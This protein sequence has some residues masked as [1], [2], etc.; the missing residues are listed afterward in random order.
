MM[1]HRDYFEALLSNPPKYIVVTPE[2]EQRFTIAP[3]DDSDECWLKLQALV[4]EAWPKISSDY[5]W[6]FSPR[7]NW[8]RKIPGW[9]GPLYDSATIQDVTE[10][11]RD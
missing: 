10:A 8:E 3:A 7:P 6:Y 1:S 9:D 11:R 5:D 2:N 4:S